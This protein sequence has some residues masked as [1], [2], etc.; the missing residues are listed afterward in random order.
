MS[1]PTVR[2]QIPQ[3]FE[4]YLR[5]LHPASDA[6]DRKTRWSEVARRNGRKIHP[7]VQWHC[8]VGS[9][10]P[11][12]AGEHWHGVVPAFGEMSGQELDALCVFLQRNTTTPD[13]CILGLSTI[14]GWVTPLTGGE[15]L[16]TLPY[17][18]FALFS[19][20]LKS[21]GELG[22]SDHVG[23]HSP[24]SSV[25]ER[26][27]GLRVV[28]S[29]RDSERHQATPET[30][31]ADNP[32]APRPSPGLQYLN[33][34]RGQAPNLMWPDD[35]AWCVVSEMDFDSTLVGGCRQLIEELLSTSELECLSID[36]GASL[37]EDADH[38]NC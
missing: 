23:A 13:N 1:L 29:A 15:S 8:L 4:S 20:P 6:D 14:H 19:G 28:P 21:A 17:R 9:P 11:M 16:L 22:L 31:P 10:D 32:D 35:R 33:G 34:I 26:H 18:Q 38:I 25:A 24:R 2:N 36:P 7:E 3:C 27:S 30:P 12:Q 37:G 5:I